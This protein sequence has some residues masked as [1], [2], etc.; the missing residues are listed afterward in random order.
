MTATCPNGHL[1]ATVDYCDQC[2]SPIATATTAPPR[3]DQLHA[4]SAEAE[5]DTSPATRRE[6]CP[7]CGA[8]RTGD[9]RYCEGCG[10]DF[11][12]PAPPRTPAPPPVLA[13]T[14]AP[15]WEAVA[16][17]DRGYFDRLA[18]TDLEFPADNVER[19]FPLNGAEVRIGRSRGRPPDQ[20]LEINLAGAGEDPA[21][22]HLHAVLERQ[23]DGSYT[24]RDLGSSNGTTINDDPTP[25]GVDVRAPVA[26]GDRIHVG[27]WTTITLRKA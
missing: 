22:S 18:P 14:D 6:P 15:E 3:T 10:Y 1:S 13:A 9:D 5:L 12:G 19:R 16:T 21:V 8:P 26:D 2:G 17:A 24:L 7:E 20:A 27:A 23:D 4:T 25:V 11:A